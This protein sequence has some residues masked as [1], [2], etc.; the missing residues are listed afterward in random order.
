[1]VPTWQ[2]HSSSSFGTNITIS[3]LFHRLLLP[4]LIKQYF[5]WYNPDD[6]RISTN[7]NGQ[8]LTFIWNAL[9]LTIV[10]SREIPIGNVHVF[11]IVCDSWARGNRVLERERERER[12]QKSQQPGDIFIHYS[13]YQTHRTESTA[14]SRVKH[15]K[16][17]RCE[18]KLLMRMKISI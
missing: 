7:I 9:W 17:G 18:S 5:Q 15:T 1:M 3:F 2:F 6:V 12:V 10:R 14:T 16:L 11:S 13:H 8:W 4:H